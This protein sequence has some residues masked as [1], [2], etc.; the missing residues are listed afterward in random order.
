MSCINP[1][2]PAALVKCLYLLVCL[3]AKKE[4]GA[5]E[6]TFQEPL[7]RVSGAASPFISYAISLHRSLA[8]SPGPPLL[9]FCQV[10]LQLCRQ[11]VN[12]ERLVQTRELQCLII[13]L[14]S[15]W[16]QTSPAWR[17]QASRVLKAISAVPTS[18]TITCLRGNIIYFFLP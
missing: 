15:L 6:E 18:N 3:P 14:T 10:L 16:D 4:N 2:L 8:A 12:A 5:I 7:T 11:H 9:P 1:G 13:G 17:H